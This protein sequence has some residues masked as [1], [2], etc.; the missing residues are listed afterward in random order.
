M[1]FSYAIFCIPIKKMDYRVRQIPVNSADLAQDGVAVTRPMRVKVPMVLGY[2]FMSD[3]SLRI[4]LGDVKKSN[5]K[6][7]L[8][9][10]RRVYVS[11]NEKFALT[12]VE[13]SAFCKTH[14]VT[15]ADVPGCGKVFVRRKRGDYKYEPISLGTQLKGG[16]GGL[17]ID[18]W[19]GE[20]IY[21]RFYEAFSPKSYR[22]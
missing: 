20:D 4:M 2:T 19:N 13:L 17:C 14:N 6:D 3:K 16:L 8:R 15:F 22:S 9:D 5:S 7:G 1:Y 11:A 18:D 10:V 21:H 12:P